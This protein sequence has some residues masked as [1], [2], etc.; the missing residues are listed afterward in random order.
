[1][2]ENHEDDAVVD[3]RCY[4]VSS[5]G[6]DNVFLHAHKACLSL[7]PKSEHEDL[8]DGEMLTVSPNLPMSAPCASPV[9][10]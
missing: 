9:S 10:H 3:Q 7:K 2:M 1:M 5:Y 4:V 6:R 8:I